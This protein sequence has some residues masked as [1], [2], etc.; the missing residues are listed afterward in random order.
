MLRLVNLFL[1]TSCQLISYEQAGT[2]S[3]ISDLVYPEDQ[4]GQERTG[5]PPPAS[6]N[7]PPSE[8]AN[9]GF[10]SPAISRSSSEGI[11]DNTLEGFTSSASSTAPPSPGLFQESSEDELVLSAMGKSTATGDRINAFTWKNIRAYDKSAVPRYRRAVDLPT[12]LQDHVNFLPKWAIRKDQIRRL[13][14][15]MIVENTLEDEPHAPP[16][17]LVNDIDDEPTPPWE[18]YYS[19]EIWHG[20]GVPA[21]D[22]KNLRGCDCKGACSSQSKTCACL[23]LQRQYTN[24]LVNDFAYDTKRH[25]Q[26]HGIPIFECNDL[27]G[28]SDECRNRVRL[29]AFPGVETHH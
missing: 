2:D 9:S 11:F 16:I 25:L 26:C 29:N 19:N 27:C 3:D 10:D 21:P 6:T 22:I 28:C 24:E 14:E 23:R 5:L 7:A 13:F 12:G 1:S 20:E 18:F 17:K 4:D 8:G 15:A